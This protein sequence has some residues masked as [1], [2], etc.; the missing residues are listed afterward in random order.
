MSP[1]ISLDRQLPPAFSN[2]CVTL[3]SEILFNNGKPTD[4]QVQQ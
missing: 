1:F 2:N 3:R 4:Q